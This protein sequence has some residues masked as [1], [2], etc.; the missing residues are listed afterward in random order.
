[1]ALR[2][3]EVERVAALALQGDSHVLEHAQVRKY[4]GDL[5]RADEAHARDRRRPRSRDVLAV[6][7]DVAA[8]RREEVREQVEAGRLAGAVGPDQRVDRAAPNRETHVIDR[9]EALELLGQAAGLE[10]RVGGHG[11]WA[12]RRSDAGAPASVRSSSA[13]IRR[14][15]GLK[16]SCESG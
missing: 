8:R 16:E 14:R 7:N 2:A 5:K 15:V 11:G 9:D 10:D 4:G 1:M 3:P 12:L 13:R 6:E